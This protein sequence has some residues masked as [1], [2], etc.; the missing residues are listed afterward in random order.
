LRKGLLLL[1]LVGLPGAAAA[2]RR[3]T[4]W[5]A[6]VGGLA[7][8]AAASF[9]GGALG[10]AYRPGGQTRAAVTLA[11]G[12][13][14]DRAAVRAEVTAQFVLMP[15]ARGGISPYAGLGLA[16]QSAERV[17]G[18]A[19]LMGLV[20]VESAAGRRFGWYAEAGVGGGARVAA[21]VRWRRFPAWWLG[22]KRKTGAHAG[23]PS[24]HRTAPAI[25]SGVRGDRR[26]RARHDRAAIP[27][28]QQAQL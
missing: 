27:L 2:Q 24:R 12:A 23:R 20:G 18:A 28:T 4:A 6:G 10:A 3:L 5:E 15:W 26:R 11:G 21:G 16:W 1:V 22:W 9:F 19:Y 13:L 14:E 25:R 7:A 17:R 8:L